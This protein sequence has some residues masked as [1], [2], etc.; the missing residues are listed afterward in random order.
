MA[1][2][3]NEQEALFSWAGIRPNGSEIPSQRCQVGYGPSGQ[4]LTM[5]SAADYTGGFGT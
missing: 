2:S 3:L 1:L 5:P 4:I